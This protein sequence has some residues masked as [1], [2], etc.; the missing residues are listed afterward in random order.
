MLGG[1]LE[2]VVPGATTAPL[3]VGMDHD[4]FGVVDVAALEKYD[5]DGEAKRRLVVLRR[6]DLD[7]EL[8]VVAT[9]CSWCG[10]MQNNGIMLSSALSCVDVAECAENAGEEVQLDIL[11]RLALRC[12]IPG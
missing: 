10:S 6:E 9:C 2:E 12:Q 1:S 7:L 3:P 8:V 11:G 4:R 5:C